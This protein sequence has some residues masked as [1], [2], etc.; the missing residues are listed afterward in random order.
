[1]ANL[2][3]RCASM[4]RFCMNAVVKG[5]QLRGVC[6]RCG[7]NHLVAIRSPFVMAHHGN[8]KSHCQGSGSVPEALLDK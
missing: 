1:M 3:N 6:P 4:L 2:T 5:L 7:G 8:G